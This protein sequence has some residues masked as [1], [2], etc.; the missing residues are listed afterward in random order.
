MFLSFSRSSIAQILDRTADVLGPYQQR[1]EITT[2]HAFAW[3]LLN[4]WGTAIGLGEPRML[5]ES[6]AK[7]FRADGTVR[8]K[9]MLPNALDLCTVPAVRRHLQA[10]WSII[11]SDE[12][13]DTDD[14][15]FELLATITG[16]TRLLLLGDPNQCIYSDLPDAVGVRPQRL[17][18]ALALPRA[19]RIDLPEVSHRDTSN[20]LPAAAAA[21]RRRDFGHDAITA[22]LTSGRLQ[23]RADLPL[24]READEVAA[25][26]QQLRDEGHTVGVFSHHI[27]ATTDLSDQLTHR[28]IDHEIIGLPDCLVA[29]LDAQ[30]AMVQFASSI[31]AWDLVRQRLAVFV[32]SSVRGKKVPDLAW[33]L[34]GR[35]TP[36]ATLSRRLTELQKALR[37]AG[38]AGGLS[39]TATAHHGLGLPRGERHWQRANHLLQPI[40]S[41]NLRRHADP[42][43]ALE[44]LDVAVAQHR[45]NLLT[46]A[47]DEPTPP[48]QLMGLYQTKGREADAT[49]VVL[50]SNDFYGYE[51]NEPFEIG[52]RLLY[53]VLTRAR[54]KTIMLLFGSDPQPLVAP[55][56]NLPHQ[57]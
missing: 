7:L 30:N 17:D 46:Y 40:V 1:V 9:D 56:A 18:A 23:I 13:Q 49:I 19:R 14:R 51:K 50:R 4:R 41:R 54:H 16:K 33:M 48:V 52:S 29:A 57:P 20:V 24:D 53:V 28:R 42:Q 43:T 21:I 38:P 55:L 22:A 6:E 8:Y 34:L 11:V 45:T 31:A 3:R 27:D 15:Q 2:F 26:V 25:V 36:P 10:R 12:F 37:E 44:H 32:T 39:I 35:A 5:S 47:I